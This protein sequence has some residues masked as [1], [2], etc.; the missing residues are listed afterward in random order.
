MNL[1]DC[2]VGKAYSFRY[3]GV[4]KHGICGEAPRTG[5]KNLWS[6]CSVYWEREVT[7]IEPLMTREE[8]VELV[9]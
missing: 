3:R 1:S 2:Q 6:V 7:D 4:E 5:E 9:A 8:A